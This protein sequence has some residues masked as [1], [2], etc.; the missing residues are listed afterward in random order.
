VRCSS[1]ARCQYEQCDV[2]PPLSSC[3]RTAAASTHSGNLA[4]SDVLLVAAYVLSPHTACG[5]NGTSS[6][7]VAGDS[8][9]MRMLSAMT[10]GPWRS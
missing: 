9:C 3:F 2:A 6:D 8:G 5:S 4:G 10:C 7:S 1:S